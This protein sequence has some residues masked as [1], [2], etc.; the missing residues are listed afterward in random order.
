VAVPIKNYNIPLNGYRG[1][2]ALAVFLFHIS[3]AG[4]LPPS[5]IGAL[6]YACSA[7]RYGVEMFFMIS[8]FVIAGSMLRQPSV[9][10]FLR[11]R[12]IRIY[13]A[14]APAVA[15]LT[16][17]LWALRFTV[18]ENATP[19]RA[20][21]IF[22]L[23]FYLVPPFVPKSLQM[24]DGAQPYVNPS[25]WSLTYECVF[26]LAAAAAL[27]LRHRRDRAGQLLRLCTSALAIAFVIAFPRALFFLPGLVVFRYKAWFERHKGLLRLPW[28]SLLMFLLAWRMTGADKAELTDT[29]LDW[30]LDGRLPF[31]LIALLAAIHMFASITL[32]ATA[33]LAF[34]ETRP[35][36]F[37]G[38]VSYSFYLW[39]A[40]LVSLVKRLV[41]ALIVSRFGPNVGMICLFCGSLALTV[42]LAWVSY[43]LCEVR[44]ARWLRGL[45]TPQPSAAAAA[46]QVQPSHAE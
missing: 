20:L 15:A 13:A 11:D 16:L 44:F 2:C 28:L 21:A 43:E 19:A 40:P 25:S 1:L 46:L 32:R 8:G 4:L 45:L 33:Q 34:L 27:A 31:A 22:L 7:L 36:Q 26:Y 42:P 30:L 9:W 17:A 39:H 37:L 3:N 12:F 23:N 18:F 5:E 41:S 10:A 38:T 14:W 6:G 24:L 35:F 29:M